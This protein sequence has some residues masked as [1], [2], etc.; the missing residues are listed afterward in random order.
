[1][2]WRESPRKAPRHWVPLVWCIAAIKKCDVVGS[3]HKHG[4]LNSALLWT[5]CSRSLNEWVGIQPGKTGVDIPIRYQWPDSRSR[6][7]TWRRRRLSVRIAAAIR[8]AAFRG[9]LEGATGVK[10]VYSYELSSWHRASNLP[11]AQSYDASVSCPV[12]RFAGAPLLSALCPDLTT[13]CWASRH[14]RS[15]TAEVELLRRSSGTRLGDC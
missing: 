8:T 1:M 5:T 9:V 13:L 10:V 7:Q 11:C 12:P 6:C 15:F 3:R 4:W 14:R 2:P